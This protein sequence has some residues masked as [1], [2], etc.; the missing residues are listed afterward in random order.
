MN[1]N[2]EHN[3]KIAMAVVPMEPKDEYRQVND[4][5]QLP[6]NVPLTFIPG[7]KPPPP[8]MVPQPIGPMGIIQVP[9]GECAFDGR[10]LH[11]RVMGFNNR[12]HH[13]PPV[14]ATLPRRRCTI[15]V[16]FQWKFTIRPS[17]NRRVHYPGYI[18]IGMDSVF[19][20]CV[21]EPGICDKRGS[22]RVEFDAPMTPGLYYITQATTR[23]ITRHVNVKH[24]NTPHN[25]IAAIRVLPGTDFVSST[26]QLLPRPIQDRILAIMCYHRREG[27]NATVFG[28]LRRDSLFTLLSYLIDPDEAPA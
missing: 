7:G 11:W 13:G 27:E 28:I 12:E 4:V 20:K 1:Q 16:C 26:F 23:S 3:Y 24:E 22:T 9:T 10:R 17:P 19:T 25:A 15:G 6:A 2:N 8:T 14:F 21:I 5:N 18:Y